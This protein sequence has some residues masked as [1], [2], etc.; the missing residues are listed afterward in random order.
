MAQPIWQKLIK[1]VELDKKV[2]TIKKDI[3]QIDEN[4]L[5]NQ[6]KISNFDMNVEQSKEILSQKKKN[7]R[8]I[9]LKI[10][11]IDEEEKDKKKK[12]DEIKDQKSY[13]ALQ[14]ELSILSIERQ[15]TEEL[16]ISAWN[17]VEALDK[18]IIQDE[19]KQ[20]DEIKKLQDVIIEK[21]DKKK[22]LLEKEKAIILQRSE[23][24][25]QVSSD[26][27]TRYEKMRS[28]VENPIVPILDSSCSV[29]Y[30][31]ILPQDLT[32]IKKGAVLHCRN[33]YRLI[34][35]NSDNEEAVF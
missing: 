1:L 19:K 14:K 13:N 3:Q 26:W 21:Q 10:N 7:T 28:K 16:L 6:K 30:Y 12:S 35:Y 11:A 18:K 23:Q 20:Q 24:A 34:Y 31:M 9:E 27:L 17:E 4:V 32:R 5:E 8:S 33:C 2:S 25:S 15:D 22:D 29:C